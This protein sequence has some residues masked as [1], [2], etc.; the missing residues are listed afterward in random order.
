MDRM[1]DYNNS[2]DKEEVISTRHSEKGNGPTQMAQVLSYSDCIVDCK[3]II[4]YGIGHIATC[5][6][7][8]FQFALLLLMKKWLNLPCLLYDPVLVS[9]EIDIVKHFDIS[10]LEVN[11]ECKRSVDRRTL[12]YMPHCGKPMYNNLLWANWGKSLENLCI[13]GNSFSTYS[14]RTPSRLLKETVRYMADITP[15][16]CQHDVPNS[17]HHKD[18]F[19]DISIHTFRKDILEA[20]PESMWK[21]CSEPVSN[22][23][24]VEIIRKK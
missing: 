3:E 24:D 14:I 7:A 2:K 17:F 20:A 12:F 1:C 15:Y 23:E 21:D 16:T 8:R 13:I 4:T 10:V 18:V 19:N 22:E 5:P 9:K 6:I 11:E